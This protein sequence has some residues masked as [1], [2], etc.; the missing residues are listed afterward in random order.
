MMD[1]KDEFESTAKPDDPWQ[2]L[3]LTRRDGDCLIYRVPVL[4][5]SISDVY[6]KFEG[7]SFEPYY[8]R[9]TIFAESHDKTVCYNE[10]P[11]YPKNYVPVFIQDGWAKLL[12]DA[13]DPKLEKLRQVMLASSRKPESGSDIVCHIPFDLKI[14]GT[15]ETCLAATA[16]CTIVKRYIIAIEL[17]PETE[18]HSHVLSIR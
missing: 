2:V 15:T 3:P 10:D 1:Y 14:T 4:D 8:Q 12:R 9:L 16:R 11:R 5:K 17:H 13:Y 6:F 7:K 18:S